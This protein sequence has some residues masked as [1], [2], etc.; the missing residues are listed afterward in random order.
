MLIFNVNAGGR[1]HCAL[2]IQAT[3]TIYKQRVKGKYLH[4]TQSP[5]KSCLFLNWS[6]NSYVLWNPFVL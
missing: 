2:N 3:P 6:R 4:E 1:N 5:L